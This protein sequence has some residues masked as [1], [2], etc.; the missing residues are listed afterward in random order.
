MEYTFVRP[1][2]LLDSTGQEVFE[3]DPEFVAWVALGGVPA[4]LG[5]TPS[6]KELEADEVRKYAKLVALRRM[7]P[8]QVSSWVDNNV[9]NLSDAKD[10]IKTL[11]LAISIIARKL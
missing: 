2:V 8:S 9:N 3:D 7:S 4:P 5:H 1:G 11:A 6:A 10:A